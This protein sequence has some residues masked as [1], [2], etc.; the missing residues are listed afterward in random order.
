MK[1][2][3]LAVLVS[4][5][6]ASTAFA[7]DVKPV[8][9]RVRASFNQEFYEATDVQWTVKSKFVKAS[10]IYEGRRV[11]AF[12]APDGES[13]GRS[14]AVPVEKLPTV[15]KRHLAKKYAA[16]TIREA[17]KFE[18]PAETAYYVSAENE[19]EAVVLK[20]EGGLISVYSRSAK[21]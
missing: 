16:Y 7:A 6:M 4:V 1:K 15:A 20:V 9:Q 5:S 19:K 12:Y 21:G 18:D 14:T 8:N 10:F 13:I 11:D 2:L 17:I 3:F